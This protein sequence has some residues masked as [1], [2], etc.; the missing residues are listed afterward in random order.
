M[1]AGGEKLP[2]LHKCLYFGVRTRVYFKEL[3]RTHVHKHF[4]LNGFLV[5]NFLFLFLLG[6]VTFTIFA[7]DVFT[8]DTNETYLKIFE[9]KFGTYLKINC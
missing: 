3:R 2:G 6:N 1:P 9:N 4:F 7:K 5:T 8:Y